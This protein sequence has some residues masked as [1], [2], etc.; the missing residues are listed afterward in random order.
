MKV[1]LS[2]FINFTYLIFIKKISLVLSKLKCEPDYKSLGDNYNCLDDP[3]DETENLYGY[4]FAHRAGKGDGSEEYYDR[5]KGIYWDDETFCYDAY[6]NVTRPEE[7]LD[8]LEPYEIKTFDVYT[9]L[10]EIPSSGDYL[11]IY[12]NK[13]NLVNLHSQMCMTRQHPISN[14]NNGEYELLI[15]MDTTFEENDLTTPHHFYFTVENPSDDN[16][17]FSFKTRNFVNITETMNTTLYDWGPNMSECIEEEIIPET[18]PESESEPEP[19]PSEGLDSTSNSE[20]IVV[21]VEETVPQTDPPTQEP[22]EREV[23]VINETFLEWTEEYPIPEIFYLTNNYTIEPHSSL[24]INLSLTFKKND[25]DTEKGYFVISNETGQSEEPFYWPYIVE[26][27][28]GKLNKLTNM[29]IILE[30]DLPV[31]LSSFSLMRRRNKEEESYNGQFCTF[32]TPNKKVFN[33]A[34]GD[35]YFCKT[36]NTECQKCKKIECKECSSENENADCTK[37]FS[38]SV[39]GQWNPK[40]GRAESLNCDLDYIDITKIK[41]NEGKGIEVPPAIHWRVT[42]DFWIW[43]SD[44]TVFYETTKTTNMNIIYKDFMAITLVSTQ[45]GLKIYATPI[46]WLYEYPTIDNGTNLEKQPD[47]EYYENY[48]E[49]LKH[50]DIIEF[51]SNTV[52][53][54]KKV[55]MEDLVKKPSSKWIYIRFAY[56]LDSSKEYLNELPESNLKIAQIYTDQTGMAFHMKKFY[57]RNNYTYLYF[58]NFY[59]PLNE[60]IPEKKNCTIYL[61][62]LNIFR[63]YIPQ[64]IITKYYNL[65]LIPKP[66]IFPQLM[67]SFPFSGITRKTTTKP[68]KF[69]MKGYSYYLRNDLGVVLDDTSETP[70]ITSYELELD[71][72]ITSLRPPRNFWRL[73]LLELNKQPETCDFETLID[74]VCNS[75]N[76]KCF[77]DNKPFICEDGDEGESD[78]PYYLNIFSLTCQKYCEYGYM[79]PPRYSSSLKRLYCSHFCDTGNKQCPSDDYKY[80]DI[81][82]NFLCSNNFFNLYY[83]CFNKDES[84]N[85]PDYAGIFFSSFLW[86]PTIYIDFGVEYEQ[87]A[88]DFW[89]FPDDRLRQKRYPAPKKD[90]DP[91]NHK[92]PEKEP[93]R[94]I[95]MSDCCKVI[96]GEDSTDRLKFFNRNT[97]KY[98]NPS[99]SRAINALDLHNWNHFVLTYFYR[100]EKA[101]YTYYLTFKNEQFVYC[102][103]DANG[104]SNV[105]IKYENW[106]DN[107]KVKLSQ[108][109]FCTFDNNVTYGRGVIKDTFEKEC[110]DAEW[111]DGFYRKLQIFDLTYSTKHPVFYS[112][113]FEDDGLNDIIKHRYIYKLDSIVDNKLLDLIGGKDGYVSWIQDN[114]AN[115]NPDKINYIIYESNYSPNGGIPTW[116]SAQYVKSYEYKPPEI[117]IESDILANSKCEII[118]SDKKCLSCK[119]EYSLFSKECLGEVNTESKPAT[120]FYKN[121]GKNMPERLSLNIDFEKIKTSPYFTIFFFIKLYGF[122]KDYPMNPKGFVKLIIFHEE[123]NETGIIIN[124]FYLAWT[125]DKDQKEKMYF[126]YNGYK[127]FSYEYFREYNFGQWI[128][129]SFAAFRENDRLFQLNMAQASILYE[130]LYIDKEYKGG[131][132]PY[133]KFTQF[134][135]TNYWVGLLGD[136]KIYNRF[137]ANAWGIIKF[138][139]YTISGI[140]D[141][142]G[143]N[144]DVPDSAITE[145][146]LKS[147]RGDSCLLSTQILNQPASNYKIECVIDNNPHFFRCSGG[148]Q[149]QTVRYHQGD[150]YK[151]NCSAC[152]GTGARALDRCLGGH[153]T[154]CGPRY[155]DDHSCETQSPVWKQWFPASNS[156]GRIV[157]REVYF[158]DYNRFKYAKVERVASPQD[159]WAI[160]FWFYTGTCHA[161]VKRVGDYKW[162]QSDTYGNNNNFKEFTMEWNYHIKITIYTKKEDDVPTTNV[163]H[164]IANCT[165][166]V[167]LEHPDLNSP[168]IYSVNML[169]RHY[170][171]SFITCGVNFQEKIFYETT[172][173]RFS[174]EIPFTSKLVSIPASDTTFVFKENSPSGYGFTFVHQLRL[175]HCYNCAHNFR[176]LDYVKTDKN[177]NAVYHNFDGV[178]NG[179]ASPKN[180]F[181]D[182][183]GRSG[184]YDMYQAADFPGYTVRYWYGE[185]VL[186]DETLYNYYDEESNSCQRH[187]NLAR[188]PT[189]FEMPS[190]ASSR[191]ARYTMDFWFFVEN[192]AELSP[193]L[194]VLWKYHMS[195]TLLRDT[196]NKNTINAICF[197]QSYRDDVDGIGGQEIIDLY[198]KALNKDKYAFYQGSSKWN[199]VRCAVDQTRKL[200]FINDNIQL[201]LEGEVIYGTTRNYRP[202]RYFKI[203]A[204]H[205]LKFQNAHDNP[206]RIFLRNIRCYKDFIDFRLMDMRFLRCGDSTDYYGNWTACYFW[207]LS[208]CFDYS[209]AYVTARWPCT[210]SR[211]CFTCPGVIDCGLPYFLNDENSDQQVNMHF[212]R[213]RELL[214][215]DDDV[216]YPTFPDIY[217]P[218]F[219]RHGQEGGDKKNC[220]NSASMCAMQ[221]YSALFWPRTGKRFLNLETLQEVMECPDIFCR[222]PDTYKNKSYCLIEKFTNNMQSCERKVDISQNYDNYQL[223]Y[224]CKPDY[225]RVYY[226]CIEKEKVPFSAMYFSNEYSFPNIVFSPADKNLETAKYVYWKDETRLASYYVEIWMKFDVLNYRNEITEREHYLYAHP[227]QIIKDP[228]DQKYKYSNIII[229]QGA[230]Y[231][232][233]TSISNYEWNKVIIE[234]IYDP[235]NTLFHIKFFLN[236]EFD[237]PELSIPNLDGNVYKLHFRGFG[238]CDKTDSYCRINDEP[239]YLRWGVAWYR[240]F[241]VW[242]ADITSLELIQACE[243]GYTQLINSQKYYFP[244]TVDY[245]YRNTIKD[246][247]DP[248]KNFMHL[249]YWVFYQGQEYKEAFDNAMRENY[250]TDN[251]DKTYVNENNYISGIS[252]DGTDYIIS[253]CSN[254]CKRC[255]SSSNVDCYECRLGYAIYGKQ[256]KVR[257]GYFFKTPPNNEECTR[258]E[259][260]T[261]HNDDDGYFNI[262]ELNP[263]TIAFYIKFFGI[264][265][266]KVKT[267]KIYYPLVCFYYNDAGECLTYLG[268]NYDNKTLVFVVNGE[269]IY[270]TRAKS[271]IGVWTHI[272]ISIHHQ[273]D[274]DHFPNMLNFMIDQSV[275]IPKYPFDTT[276]EKSFNPTLENI[277]IN[278]FTIYTEPIAYYSSLKVFSTFYFGPYGHVNAIASIRGS[279]LVYQ[280]NLYGSSNSNCITNKDLAKFIDNT[281]NINI[282]KPV[283]VPDYHPYEDENNIC[284]D[285]DHFMDV[286]YKTTPP[287]ELC[288]SICITNCF[289]F[290]SNECTCDYYEGLYWVKTDEQY[291]MYE[292][293]KID[294]I[295]F[296]FFEKVVIEGLNIVEN[297]EMSMVFWLDIYEYLDYKFE[298]LEVIWDQHIAVTIHPDEERNGDKYLVIKCHGDYD[299]TKNFSN[300][301][302]SIAIDET[303]N[304]RFNRWN[305]IV[306]Q[307]DK[308]HE[309]IRVDNLLNESYTKIEYSNKKELT[310]SLTI[311]DKTQ[312]FNY[313]FSF[314][315]ELKLFS[316]FNFDFWND[317]LHNLQ[318]EHFPY[319][320][321]SFNNRFSGDKISETKMSDIVEGLVKTLTLKKNRI[322]YNYVIN[323]RYLVIC[324]EGYVYN[325][326]TDK[327]DIFESEECSIP[328]TGEDKCLV[329][330]PNYYLKDDDKCYKDCSP[331]YFADKYFQQCRRCNYTC[332]TCFGKYFNNCL[333]CT[334][335]YYYIESLHICVTNCQQYGLVIS[336]KYNNTCEELVTESHIDVP[337]LLNNTYD[338]NKEN[339]DY[340]SKI[341][342]RDEFYEIH[343]HLGYNSTVISTEWKYNWS[344]TIELNKNYTYINTTEIP[345]ENPIISD[346]F[347]LDIKVDNKYFKWGIIYVFDLELFSSNGNYST[348]HTH[349]YKL[350]MNDYPLV[351]DI[352]ILPSSGYITN[353]FLITINK[354]EDDVSDKSKLRYQFSY[355]KKSESVINGFVNFTD[356]EIIIQKWSRNSEVL[357]KF[358]ELNPDEDHFYYVRGFCRDEFGVFYSEIKKVQV[359][360]IPTNSQKDL[361]LEE[362]LK[363]IDLDEDL[364][365]E[366]L[367]NRA[368]FLATTTVDF[369][370]GEVEILN[371][372]DITPITKKGIRQENLILNDPTDSQRDLYCNHRGNSYIIYRYLICDCSGYEGSMCQID[373]PSLDSTIEVYKKLFNK[374]KTMQTIHYNK[375][376]INSVNLLMKSGAQFMPIENMDFM[377]DSIE[378]INLYRNKFQT[379]MM[380]GKNYEIYFDIYN[381][382]IEY[383]LSIVN[384][385]KY[386]NFIAENSK[387]AEGLYNADKFRNATLTKEQAVTIQNYFNKIKTSLQSLLDFYSLNKKEL[388]FINRNINVYVSLINEN[389]NFDTYYDEEKKLYEPYMDFRRCLEKMM[390]KSEGTPSYR[391]F[392]NSI[393]WKVS[394]YM[395]D[396][397]LYWNTSSPVISMKFT[398]YDDGEKIYLSNCGETEDQIQLYFPVNNYRLIERIN[399]QRAY[400]SPENQ[401]D[402]NDDIFCDPVYIN[403]SGAVFNTT[404]EER[405]NT[406]FLGFNFTCDYYKVKEEDKNDIS[407]TTE[408]LDYHKYTDE[409]YV[410]CLTN[411]LVQEA[412]SEFVV[413]SYLIPND[414]HINSRFFYL[415]HYMLL[416][417]KANFS[418]NQA[419]YYF[420]ATVL[421]Y[422]GLSLGYIY[423]EKKHVILKGRLVQLKSEMAKI[424]MPY[425]DEYIF[426][427]DLNMEEEIKGRLKDKRKPDM[428]EMN[429]DTNNLNVGIMAD[430][431]T[432]Y[433]KGYSNK[434][435]ALGFDPKYFGIKEKPKTNVN[436]RYFPGEIDI[437]KQPDNDDEISPE[438]L[439]KIKKFYH[440]GFKGLD[441]KENKKKELKINDDKKKIVVRK[442]DFLDDI[443]EI[444]ED[445]YEGPYKNNFF[446]N[447]DEDIKE[448]ETAINKKSRQKKFSENKNKFKEFVSSTNENLDTDSNLKASKRETNAKKF[449]G[450]NPPRKGEGGPIMSSMVFTEKDRQKQ[451][452]SNAAFFGNQLEGTHKRKEKN[453]FQKDYDNMYKANFKGPKVVSENLGFYN[454]DTIDFEQEMDEENKNP[455]YFGKRF[456]NIKKNDDDR[457]KGQNSDM[458]VGFYTK[459]RQIDLDDNEE[460]L[461]P[462]AKNLTFEQRME[463]FH[464]AS[465]YFTSFLWKNLKSRHILITTFDKKSI[466]YERYQ[467]AG[468]FAAQI[469]MFAF[470]MSIFFTADAKQTAYVTG[471]KDEILNFVL[472]CFLSDVAGCIVV[473]LPAYCF[474]IN[475]KKFRH[476]YH[477]IREDGGITVLKET[478]DIIYKGRTFWKILG[479]IIQILYIIMG[480]YFAFGFCSTYYYQRTTF[481]LALI[482][483]L[484][485]DFFVTDIAWEILIAF[486]YYFRDIGRIIVFFGTLFNKLRDIKHLAQ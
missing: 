174:S 13:T 386:R 88:I 482:C 24:T 101:H 258:I 340:V 301:E 478:E 312:N 381:S 446:N 402:M 41:I 298:S 67:V 63:E 45:D 374:V 315:R 221:N 328:R 485:L 166:I 76:D 83:K 25:N 409:N 397:D 115:Q 452:K 3:Q 273:L 81:Y 291:Q 16:V 332:Y 358:P 202:F 184:S 382:L 440:V 303:K 378:F 219:C 371:R 278:T 100:L 259:I 419:F 462:L 253:A 72:E 251:F 96:F 90:Y 106:R 11:I 399:R 173:N 425:R 220:T 339:D 368:E 373:Y 263:K 235:D 441:P 337:V 107:N 279:K 186:C 155:Y 237:N 466:I 450:S 270:A 126:F 296:G 53:S 153:D 144:D 302:H 427:N 98:A 240:N 66:S 110:K 192:S 342:N 222:P 210:D 203:N 353:L 154:P 323:Y 324:E 61:R 415:K 272:G 267:D 352:N 242:D 94:I 187:Y 180:S 239:A 159:V 27:D 434:D 156:E 293:Q 197:P 249:N 217:L 141:T 234:N 448:K 71:E 460:E 265:L 447:D 122:V 199:F 233:L 48:V 64:N 52:G 4:E 269:E 79:H 245:V 6:Y 135:I 160:D 42:M 292:C 162:D 349:R 346:P 206:T 97:L 377:L 290:E 289:H 177:F 457:G 367:S 208:L 391:V 326:V 182:S 271:Y 480:F 248:D 77:E 229:S 456:K 225:V 375:H 205:P 416:F 121:P 407:L 474:W 132:Y 129:V 314:V 285:N 9:E 390:I 376:L 116:G 20:V 355:F 277:I 281:L 369:D 228:I 194:N 468:N 359:F 167:V 338:Y 102:G 150:G 137:I 14:Y 108:I 175:W 103:D 1:L 190:I 304:I 405:I 362:G 283:C 294:S 200:F 37:C 5:W 414:F 204:K 188:M 50:A 335:I 475:D 70:N 133:V 55:T 471:N 84:I 146:D 411:K 264:E 170:K 408:T 366:Q 82:T 161:V 322:G 394:P 198:D 472:Y 379:E 142:Q 22:C 93:K 179:G 438:R 406:F 12:H 189:N 44:A 19:E 131:Y 417:W 178:N 168:E 105:K 148:M 193:G 473:H 266:S 486:L 15:K 191:N 111:L 461:P 244:L 392:L 276:A 17:T 23:I 477:T 274:N 215:V 195:I 165:P 348:N 403:K 10:D 218:K 257:T 385:L 268:Y 299:V 75:P 364:T 388:R 54:Y 297:D 69:E 247:I 426:N 56:N 232:T 183:A 333:S 393:V 454:R 223:K 196:A 360:D 428:E 347:N 436:S 59:H 43:I 261:I 398:D 117:E 209:D 86:T 401:Y 224:E 260:K 413:D 143:A 8:E 123:K 343:G 313:G 226:E 351:G 306:C 62:N 370:K 262:T 317:S 26:E 256:C 68:Y 334:G 28:N 418:E 433:N 470:F 429:L 463:E 344:A 241:R 58:Q 309:V 275:L 80:T 29:E 124:E 51:L 305:Y 459:G 130:N 18:E 288:D 430:Q 147:E 65:H 36:N 85:S 2:F 60:E 321:H 445:N 255:Y 211:N 284:S 380:E 213:W 151:G 350:I 319:L 231:Y 476:L 34:C 201:D 163:Y 169:D 318:P 127:L 479:I 172:T 310:T 280:I 216:Y 432:R 336:S 171:W 372:T 444:D 120:Y 73:N 243:Y 443:S 484:V 363:S 109:I 356:D 311:E 435:N 327:C 439:H 383:G 87:F 152:C 92:K 230:Y 483:T 320:L 307:A 134:T 467:R 404:P 227:H 384:K 345:E 246:R 138:Q 354:C 412:Y 89:Y 458:R 421:A 164:Y 469:A 395:S 481:I 451:A 455:P 396:L 114:T 400:L 295:N 422:A 185:P 449:F 158:I 330:N 7:S 145:I 329:C 47:K 236:Y 74:L 286:I 33:G 424:N 118:Q 140:G 442:K 30:S 316:S 99:T 35:G 119:P 128:P 38:I 389:F 91:D 40:G 300:I 139:H 207:P 157:C 49:P 136:V 112:H 212:H 125:P 181:Y 325:N 287:C 410:Q 308:F 437:R 252:D 431:I 465:A 423:F 331:N 214:K 31:G 453:L 57:G 387:N 113:E 357:Y 238:F 250:S 341:I 21:E 365:S 39:E 464:D 149:V 104:D 32:N 361:P 420:I 282:L 46:E 95:F 78:K 254:E 176:N